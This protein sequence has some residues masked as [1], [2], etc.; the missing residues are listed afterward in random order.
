MTVSLGR[1]TEKYA[2]REYKG[3]ISTL[4]SKDDDNATE[5]VDISLIVPC[6]NEEDSIPVF[7]QETTQA[8]AKLIE[9]EKI[10]TS[11]FI[12][13]DDGSIDKTLSVLQ[14]LGQR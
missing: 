1:K 12:F 14:S 8:L 7:Y 10:S 4:N 13:V 2:S 9:T 3:D 11:E 5:T 6:F